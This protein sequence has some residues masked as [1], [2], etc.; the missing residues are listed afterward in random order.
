MRGKGLIDEMSSEEE[1]PK[2]VRGKRK[3]QPPTNGWGFEQKK[4]KTTER[5][6][7]KGK[8]E[9]RKQKQGQQNKKERRGSARGNGQGVG[10]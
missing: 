3:G 6:T 10:E 9:S 1:A 8:A 2:K 4:R 5:R 7:R